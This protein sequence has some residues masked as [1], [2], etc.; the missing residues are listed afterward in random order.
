MY[1]YDNF[2]RYSNATMCNLMFDTKC[3]KIEYDKLNSTISKQ[4]AV[5]FLSLTAF[6][7]LG[8]MYLTYFFRYRRVT[9]LP[10]LLISSGYYYFF[11]KVNNIAYKLIVDQKVIAQARQ[12]ELDAHIQPV[13]HFKN[14]NLN[15]I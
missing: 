8:F 4:N 3:R 6:H 5:Y 11:T 1:V 13:G 10:T 15:F 14:R 2:L 9:L 7:T 12:F